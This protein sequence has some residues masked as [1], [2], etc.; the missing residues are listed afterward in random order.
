MRMRG[1]FLCLVSSVPLFAQ[2]GNLTPPLPNWGVPTYLSDY[3]MPSIDNYQATVPFVPGACTSAP[4]GGGLAFTFSINDNGAIP[5]T[6]TVPRSTG[7]IST[8]AVVYDTTTNRMAAT[9]WSSVTIANGTYCGTWNGYL[10]TG[11]TP[12]KAS[13][14]DSYQVRLLH[15]NVQYTWDG[16]VGVTES[17]LSGPENWDSAGSFPA[18]MSFLMYGISGQ[19]PSDWGVIADGYNEGKIESSVF[20]SYDSQT[21]AGD[22]DTIWPLNLALVSGG[23]FDFTATDGNTVY[24]AARV[25]D[26]QHSNA[27]VGFALSNTLPAM[28]SNTPSEVVTTN[29]DGTQ[30]FASVPLKTYG[31]PPWGNPYIFTS[32]AQLLPVPAGLPRYFTNFVANLVLNNTSA[33]H[34]VNGVPQATYFDNGVAVGPAITGSQTVIDP[35][36]AQESISSYGDPLTGLAVQRGTAAPG[37]LLAVAHGSANPLRCLTQ[38]TSGNSISLWD[39][40]TGASLGVIGLEFNSLTNRPVNPAKMA[41]DLAG[42]LWMIDQGTPAIDC[43]YPNSPLMG[44]RQGVGR[45]PLWK[46]YGSL[47]EIVFGGGGTKGNPPTVKK[48]VPIPSLSNNSLQLSNPVDIAVSPVTGHLF[49]ADGGTNQQVFEFDP[50]T[51]EVYSSTGTPGGYGQSLSK[52]TN[53]CNPAIESTTFWLD[54]IGRGTGVTRSWISVDNEDRLW[55]G[56][57]STSRI[58]RFAKSGG[59]YKY[60]G[61][62][63]MN[64]FQYLVSVPRNAPTRVFAGTSG[65]LEY[66]VDYPTPDPAAGSTPPPGNTA[67]SATP[68]RNWLPCVLQ[69]EWQNGGYTDSTI[70]LASV[71]QFDGGTFGSVRYHSSNPAVSN[72]HLLVSLPQNGVLGIENGPT[73]EN[74]NSLPFT[75]GLFFDATGSFYTTNLSNGK[76]DQSS[77]AGWSCEGFIQYTTNGLDTNGFPSWKVSGNVLG[78]VNLGLV[79]GDPQGRCGNDG[80]DLAPT[81]N[82]IIP[83]YSGPGWDWHSYSSCQPTNSACSPTTAPTYHLGGVA[84]GKN[85][86]QWHAQLEVNIEYQT[87]LNDPGKRNPSLPSSTSNVNNLGL[88]STWTSYVGP[89][90]M[91]YES[92]SIDNFIFSG[93]SGNWQQFGCQFYQ[94]TD[95]G[96]L[97]GQF[98]WRSTGYYPGASGGAPTQLLGEAL[99]PG[100]CGNPVMFKVVKVNGDYYL[101]VTDEGYRA[102][103]QRW[104]IWNTASIG[105]LTGTTA[106][107]LSAQGVPLTLR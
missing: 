60:T 15:N 102:G 62:S 58:L 96:I 42:N 92:H 41:F 84:V 29:S 87:L 25:G 36:G 81:A 66:A 19:S 26:S 52:T 59:Q 61:V 107:A 46:S 10:D 105:T 71:E 75:K 28:S 85:A 12:T 27:V 34:S 73:T 55:I 20:K 9:L 93:V 35:S 95:D 49:L 53:S 22:P 40:N 99:A 18:G 37:N 6:P 64:R 80:C 76:C 83:L 97:I 89:Q 30:N 67:F 70:Q 50:N 2:T 45:D 90:N 1:L 3:P 98:G 78:T 72:R 88:Y 17:S 91:G 86:T 14:G 104:H 63:E 16:M 33:P 100:R 106:A 23:E 7:A 82:N 31:Q 21:G 68:V 39:K 43:S 65:M 74:A 94:H 69:S 56:D 54:F 4:A 32:V 13:P 101:Y 48:I 103:I 11:V 57:E 24:F 51:L 38:P 79:N 47:I 5:A 77:L 8:S 44:N